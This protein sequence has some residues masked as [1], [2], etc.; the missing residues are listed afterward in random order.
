MFI[1]SNARAT[2]RSGDPALGL[3][4]V[5]LRSE[6]YVPTMSYRECR[7]VCIIW[8]SD[9]LGDLGL[10]TAPDVHCLW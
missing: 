1:L 2:P 7:T 3:E 4:S 10:Q 8:E 9:L 6:P 5:R